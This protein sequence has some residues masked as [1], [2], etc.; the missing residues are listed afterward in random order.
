[1]RHTLLQGAMQQQ[2]VLLGGQGQRVNKTPPLVRALVR[3]VEYKLWVAYG[4]AS[5]AEPVPRV[6]VAK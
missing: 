3:M 5:G 1:M 2:L 4:H 6:P